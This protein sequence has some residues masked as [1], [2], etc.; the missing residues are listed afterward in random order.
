M[1]RNTITMWIA[2]ILIL[3]LSLS[4]VAF[5]EEEAESVLPKGLAGHWHGIGVNANNTECIA[6]VEILE[7]GTGTFDLTIVPFFQE[8][9]PIKLDV[10]TQSFTADIGNDSD[11]KGTY[12]LNGD[13]LHIEYTASLGGFTYSYVFECE[14]VGV[15][16]DVEWNAYVLRVDK[17]EEPDEETSFTSY[18]PNGKLLLYRLMDKGEGIPSEELTSE[19]VQNIILTA[20]DGTVYRPVVISCWGA[21]YSQEKGFYTLPTQ[22]GFELVYDVPVETDITESTLGVEKQAA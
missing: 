18:V 4:S 7:N 12:A 1:K 9:Y 5:A 2:V 22:E 19:S 20:A 13:T 10:S 21:G 16:P 15:L 11:V 6:E 14:R 17:A 8:A 3:C